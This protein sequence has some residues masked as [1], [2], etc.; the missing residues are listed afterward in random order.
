MDLPLPDGPVTATG[1]PAYAATADV[2]EDLTP[3]ARVR[4]AGGRAARRR[5]R[6]RAAARRTGGRP[7][8][9]ASSPA[10]RPRVAGT[11][12]PDPPAVRQA[13]A[14]PGRVWSCRASSAGC[15]SSASSHFSQ[16][17]RRPRRRR[18]GPARR[19]PACGRPAPSSRAAGRRARRRAAVPSRRRPPRRTARGTCEWSSARPATIVTVRPRAAAT[20][21]SWVTATRVVPNRSVTSRSISTTRSRLGRSSWLVGSSASSRP[22]RARER[23][24]QRQP[25]RLTARQPADH[26]PGEVGEVQA[27]QQLRRRG[28]V[29]A[30]RAAHRALREDDVV[31]GGAVRQQVARRTLDDDAD[32]LRAQ[33]RAARA[34]SS[35]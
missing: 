17:M 20:S 29:G 30:A 6:G 9:S 12:P 19:R 5:A 22:G 26:L 35:G 13:V 24:G 16:L 31:L 33:E 11:R 34:R 23:D 18:D 4:Q 28:Q 27:A 14:R 1:S 7:G 15:T 8:G 25:L 2:G 32:P 21:A 3:V 10:R